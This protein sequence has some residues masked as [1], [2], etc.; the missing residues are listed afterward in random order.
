MKNKGVHQEEKKVTK[1]GGG[2][3]LGSQKS[4]N[5]ISSQQYLKK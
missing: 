2:G 1:K 5:D 3:C 4:R